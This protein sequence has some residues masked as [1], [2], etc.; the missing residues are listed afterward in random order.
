MGAS[1]GSAAGTGIKPACATA[2]GRA[3]G[4]HKWA[5]AHIDAY[6][7]LG[8]SR[9]GGRSTRAHEGRARRTGRGVDRL[10]GRSTRKGLPGLGIGPRVNRL[11]SACSAA[12]GGGSPT[13]PARQVRPASANMTCEEN[14]PPL[15]ATAGVAL[16]RK[17]VSR[18]AGED[19]RLL[20]LLQIVCTKDARRSSRASVFATPE[21][22]KIERS[23]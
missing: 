15:V 20:A 16:R 7:R 9:G 10:A 23:R 5:G 11:P 8:D 14:M 2:P 17:R 4:R 3:E 12:L 18:G 19:K 13:W 21:V 6:E 22:E 1:R